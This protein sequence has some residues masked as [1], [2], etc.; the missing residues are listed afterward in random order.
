[1]AYLWVAIG[2]ALG[3]MA[4][5]WANGLISERYGAS[6]PWGTLA[7]NMGG[8]FIIG[9]LAEIASPTGRLTPETRVFTTQLM[10]VGLCGGFT[11]FSSFSL[12]TLQL[13][14]DGQWLYAGGNIIL[15]V[16]ICM[17]AV[18]LGYLTGALLER[19]I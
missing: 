16:I 17:V 7:I 8:S 13:L 9:V 12:Q 2:G 15:S 19:F 4:R 6:F 3:S 11:T 14:Q 1:M 10:M 5:Y 18:W